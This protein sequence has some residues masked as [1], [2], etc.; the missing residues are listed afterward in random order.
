MGYYMA[1]LKTATALF[2]CHALTLTPYNVVVTE[3]R[4]TCMNDLVSCYADCAQPH[5][6]SNGIHREWIPL[7][8]FSQHRSRGQCWC[9]TM[10]Y[11]RA[12]L[13]T[14][15]LFSATTLSHELLADRT[16]RHDN[17]KGNEKPAMSESFLTGRSLVSRRELRARLI[18]HP[19]QSPSPL[20]EASSR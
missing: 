4:I 9:I 11:Y 18:G 20:L 5:D 8:G 19:A 14:A 13:K 7:I 15:T 1:R 3:G 6:N 16:L 10:E 17:G 2:C 12:P